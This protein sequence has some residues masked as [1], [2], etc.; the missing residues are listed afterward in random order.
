VLDL[1]TKQVTNYCGLDV[2]DTH[3][4]EIA[5]E[6]KPVWSP[7][8]SQLLVMT[9][10]KKEQLSYN[11]MINGI[12][13]DAKVFLVDLPSGTAAPMLDNLYPVGWLK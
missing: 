10:L 4:R 7:D 3:N 11:E 2:T 8:G 9:R 5:D 6:L 12:D 1:Q 13:K